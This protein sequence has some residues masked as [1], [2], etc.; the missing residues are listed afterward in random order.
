LPIGYRPWQDFR[1]I[2]GARNVDLYVVPPGYRPPQA[3]DRNVRRNQ[4]NFAPLQ[5]FNSTGNI[6]EYHHRNQRLQGNALSTYGTSNA[7]TYTQEE[8]SEDTDNQ[9]EQSTPIVVPENVVLIV[10]HYEKGEYLARNK[11]GVW[12]SKLREINEKASQGDYWESHIE[13]SFVLDDDTRVSRI[14]IKSYKVFEYFVSPPEEKTQYGSWGTG[15]RKTATIVYYANHLYETIVP[16][17]LPIVPT[18]FFSQG[19][20]EPPAIHDESDCNELGRLYNWVCFAG[21]F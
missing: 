8:L 3:P 16:P 10:L 7:I 15:L 12:D 18:V 20:P 2:P 9:A 11:F 14:R 13:H 5:Q 6:V 4:W 19:I 1:G 21:T 17:G